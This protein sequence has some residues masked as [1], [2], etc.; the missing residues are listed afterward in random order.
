MQILFL[1]N[2]YLLGLHPPRV[3]WQNAMDAGPQASELMQMFVE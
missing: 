2:A 3:E 1:T